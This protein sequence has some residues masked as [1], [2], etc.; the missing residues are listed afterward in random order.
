MSTAERVQL[1]CDRE[2]YFEGGV[3]LNQGFPAVQQVVASSNRTV[4]EDPAKRPSIDP[5]SSLSVF[6]SALRAV[7]YT[8]RAD[9]YPR[10]ATSKECMA[11]T[12]EREM[13]VL[14]RAIVEGV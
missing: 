11:F 7:L 13:V 5:A 2:P 1:V 10:F 8:L 12:S 6:T 3:V 9:C 14:R 4:G